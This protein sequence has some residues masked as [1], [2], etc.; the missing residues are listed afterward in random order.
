MKY[1]KITTEEQDIDK[2]GKHILRERLVDKNGWKHYIS[3]A[4]ECA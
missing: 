3:R 2:L 4:G 1:N